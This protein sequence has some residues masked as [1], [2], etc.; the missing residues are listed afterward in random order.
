[1]GMEM[2]MEYENENGRCS[3]VV[4]GDSMESDACMHDSAFITIMISIHELRRLRRQ[5]TGRSYIHTYSDTV[6]RATSQPY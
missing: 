3:T 6:Y 4:G 5:S 2:E 1:M